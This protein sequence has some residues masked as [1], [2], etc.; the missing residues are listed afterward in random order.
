MTGSSWTIAV[1]FGFAFEVFFGSTLMG[2][3]AFS[4]AGEAV[5]AARVV[6]A[7]DFLAA[8]LLTTRWGGST[9][10]GDAMNGASC[11]REAQK[12]SASCFIECSQATR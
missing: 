3:F 8:S 4:G 12:D 7:V 11:S 9:R 10:S 6:S 2:V 5:L 1:T